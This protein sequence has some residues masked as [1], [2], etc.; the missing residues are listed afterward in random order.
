MTVRS[1]S[2]AGKVATVTG[3]SRGIGRA[4]A[5]RLAAEGASVAASGRDVGLLND[6]IAEITN[7]GGHAQAFAYDLLEMNAPESLIDAIQARFSGIDILVN[8]AG[9]TKRGDFLQQSDA[10][11]IDGF[12]LKFFAAVRLTRLAWP[13]LR[14]AKGAVLNIA[15]I[16]ARTPIADFAVGASVNAALLAF[17]KAMAARGVTDGVRVNAIN[18]GAVRTGRFRRRLDAI[19]AAEGVDAVAAE[20]RFVAAS[21]I[22]RVGEPADVANLAAFILSEQG[23]WLQG[24]ILDIDGGETKSL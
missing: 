4:I 3:A 9:A 6:L 17:T 18:P 12:G 13:Q 11:W 19:I 8:S 16:G 14:K 2:L 5:L 22:T 21:A 15:G 7:E 24:A 1:S 20:A 10:D 23:A